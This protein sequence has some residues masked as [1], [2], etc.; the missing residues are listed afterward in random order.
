VRSVSTGPTGKPGTLAGTSSWQIDPAHSHVEFAVRHLMISSVK[1]RFGDV[2][3]TVSVDESDARAVVVDVTI[4]VASID[5][6]QEQ[7]DAHLRSADFF[8]EARFPTITFRSRKVEGH[9]LDGEFR[10]LGDLTIRDVTREVILDVS[11]EGRLTDPWGAE[12]AGFSARGK[13]DRT[14]FGLTWNQT[15]EAGGVLVGNEVKI[16]VEVELIRQAKQAAA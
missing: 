1:G 14:D 16:A 6:R 5:T 7:R 11:A 3:G 2:Q 13:I 9:H 15:L 12:R 4:Q 10:L 8:D